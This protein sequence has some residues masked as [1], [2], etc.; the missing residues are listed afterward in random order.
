[1]SDNTKKCNFNFNKINRP[2]SSNVVAQDDRITYVSKRGLVSAYVPAVTVC[3]KLCKVNFPC[4]EK[5]SRF[6]LALGE[7]RDNVFY[8]GGGAYKVTNETTPIFFWRASLSHLDGIKDAPEID[9]SLFLIDAGGIKGYM[10]DS[11]LKISADAISN[12]ELILASGVHD[13]TSGG[14]V[15]MTVINTD[16]VNNS[17]LFVLNFG[18]DVENEA[19]Y[20]LGI[21]INGEHV[22][23]IGSPSGLGDPETAVPITTSFKSQ[24]IGIESGDNILM[25]AWNKAGI[26]TCMVNNIRFKFRLNL[27]HYKQLQFI[28]Y[29]TT[30]SNVAKT[31]RIKELYL[32]DTAENKTL[33]DFYNSL[34]EKY[35][36]SSFEF[37]PDLYL[38]IKRSTASSVIYDWTNYPSDNYGEYYNYNLRGY[39]AKQTYVNTNS[40]ANYYGAILVN[41]Y[42]ES[43]ESMS[44]DNITF[45]PTPASGFTSGLYIIRYDGT[46]ST[47]LNQE[48]P[49][50]I[51]PQNTGET[52][53]YSIYSTY[54]TVSS[55][56]GTM[57]LHLRF[58]KK[59][60]LLNIPIVHNIT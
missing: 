40:S 57:T 13:N 59:A 20:Q 32:F 51:F 39:T 33:H 53:N 1:M 28:G 14:G 56:S 41:L 48:Y 3:S 19:S 50:Q 30:Q 26:I 24:K 5:V 10:E 29:I 4:P 60:Y 49:M 35:S 22:S 18:D 52:M 15:F 43:G 9:N 45:S 47:N 6:I 25:L 55:Y 16:A 17:L 46:T 58:R 34:L 44:L 31:I 38:F 21:S 2:Q 7:G 23:I 27:A 54:H 42:N 12:N 11:H 36:L 37:G 8:Y